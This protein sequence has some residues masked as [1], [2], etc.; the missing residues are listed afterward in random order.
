LA[1][2]FLAGMAFA[3]T[4]PGVQSASRGTG[5]TIINPAATRMA[6]PPFF[7]DG[8][9]RFQEVENVSNSANVGLG[10]RLTQIS[11][12][13]VMRNLRLAEQVLPSIPNSLFASNGVA[14]GNTTPYFITANGPTREARFPFF[15]NA[16]GTAEHQR[17]QW[18]SG[19]PVHGDWPLRRR[20]L[21]SAA[22]QFRRG[23]RPTTSSSAFPPRSLA[24][25]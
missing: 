3:Q 22:A 5:A 1:V 6:S 7:K 13:H 2:L 10:P 19:R 18:R 16:N 20:Q 9:A 25:A 17:S 12:V 11:A 4:D 21:Q 24:R 14:P 23:G 8:L 15:F